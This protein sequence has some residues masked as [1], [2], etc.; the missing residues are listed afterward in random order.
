MS[1]NVVLFPPE[2]PISLSIPFD[3][4]EAM[5]GAFDAVE[6]ALELARRI[7]SKASVYG[8][9]AALA[10]ARRVM[11]ATAHC[12]LDPDKE[13]DPEHAAAVI[14][15]LTERAKERYGEEAARTVAS[16]LQATL[17]RAGAD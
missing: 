8:E 1:E 6:V 10:S 11:A 17:P 2:P 14:A 9:A 12:L 3:S 16:R 4:I 7:A 13:V 15:R 5:T